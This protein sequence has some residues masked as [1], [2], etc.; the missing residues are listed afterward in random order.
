[1]TPQEII[2]QQAEAVTGFSK[3]SAAEHLEAAAAL[4]RKE[5]TQDQ[6]QVVK[7][8]FAAA[9]EPAKRGRERFIAGFRGMREGQVKSAFAGSDWV[10]MKE[11]DGVATYCR[12]GMGH[13]Y[14]NVKGDEFS[15]TEGETTGQYA[16]VSNL[17][18]FIS[19]E[20]KKRGL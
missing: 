16:L 13:L 20:K 15:V 7:Q 11:G 17:A 4:L 14:I 19:E 6:K 12:K 9:K 3:L 2:R 10:K 5:A 18:A 1:M 8:A